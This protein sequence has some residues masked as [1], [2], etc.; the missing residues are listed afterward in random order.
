MIRYRIALSALLLLG[1]SASIARDADAAFAAMCHMTMMAHVHQLYRESSEE[2]RADMADE[3][4]RILRADRRCQTRKVMV[5]MIA[6]LKD[7]NYAV[8]G[9]AA[10]VLAEFGPSANEAIPAL[11]KALKESDAKLRETMSPTETMMPS[12]YEGYSIR[13]ALKAITGKEPEEFH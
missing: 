11:E 4:S 3:L 10:D 8:R 7:E 2:R 6:L 9:D 5:E 1:P 12:Q 13:H